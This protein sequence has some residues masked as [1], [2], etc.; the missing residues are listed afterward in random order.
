MATH[1]SILDG[2]TP[3]T[4]ESVRE[5]RVKCDWATEHVHAHTHTMLE[6]S[7]NNNLLSMLD[8]GT[9]LFSHLLFYLN[10]EKVLKVWG[11]FQQSFIILS[12]FRE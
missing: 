3:L 4:E 12:N 5:G 8:I 6:F 1:S 11:L 10:L 7:F 2:K 9:I